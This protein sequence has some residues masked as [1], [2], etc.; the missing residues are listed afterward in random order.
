MQDV[1]GIVPLVFIRRFRDRVQMRMGV[2]MRVRVSVQ[3]G[4]V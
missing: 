2:H 3:A 1:V 4:F